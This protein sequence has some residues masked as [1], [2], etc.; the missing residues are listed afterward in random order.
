MPK[1]RHRQGL[2]MQQ[3]TAKILMLP[4]ALLALKTAARLAVAEASAVVRPHPEC[5]TAGSN[6]SVLMQRAA[7]A[8]TRP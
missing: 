2:R 7:A 4:A 8:M 1:S 3:T 5:K 6:N